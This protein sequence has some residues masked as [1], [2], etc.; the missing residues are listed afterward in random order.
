MSV[1]LTIDYLGL[2]LD[3]P[4]LASACPLTSNLESLQRLRDAGA[5]AAVLPSIFEE[6]IEHEE[7]EVARMLDFWALSSPETSDY[8]PQLDN[9]NTGPGAYLKLIAD[10]KQQLDMPIIASLNGSTM[11]GWVRYAG[12]IEQAGAAALELNIYEVSCDPLVDARQAEEEYFK[13]IRAVR[14]TIQIP[15]AVKIGPY[16]SALP[17]FARELASLGVNGLVLFNRYLAPD[18]ELESLEYVPALELSTPSELRLALRWI[19]ILRDQVELSLAATGG[20]HSTQD[21]VKSIAAGAN[22][23][24]CASALLS[25]GPH[26]FRELKQGLQQW[27]TEHEYTSVKQL[28]G[29]MSLKHCPNPEGL[30][31]A[32]YMRALTSYT[33]S[34]SVDSVST[35]PVST[36]P[37]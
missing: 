7:M 37:R 8:F 21:V 11:G 10:A 20:V 23:V 14:D 29:S 32:N 34:V 4:L 18:I 1:D 3:S 33:P 15:I 25:R 16:F 35:D 26:A 5:A 19:A 2:Q 13:L 31:R 24:A 30:K 17:H 28:Q 27:L 12:L 9:Y 36:D 6:Q 22:V